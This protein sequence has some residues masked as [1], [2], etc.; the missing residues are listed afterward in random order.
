MIPEL[1]IVAA[2]LFILV[3]GGF[4]ADLHDVERYDAR[5]RNR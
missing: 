5:R 4:L 1:L 2:F 3:I